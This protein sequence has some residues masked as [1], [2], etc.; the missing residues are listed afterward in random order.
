V[1]DSL[2]NAVGGV[3]SPSLDVPVATLTGLVNSGGSFCRLFGTTT[4]FD[5]PTLTRLYPTHD[6][7]VQAFDRAA[8]RAQLNGW[9]L[10]T[11]AKHFTDAARQL[12]VPPAG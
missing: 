12:A 1:R 9:M 10:P 2:G 7:Y 3:R 4:P 8:L 11:E 5:G 6:Q